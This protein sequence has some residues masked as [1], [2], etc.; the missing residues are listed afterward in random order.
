MWGASEA[1]GG[2][3]LFSFMDMTWLRKK[4]YLKS[5]GAELLKDCIRLSFVLYHPSWSASTW[6]ACLKHMLDQNMPTCKNLLVEPCDAGYK[7]YLQ[8]GLRWSQR[9]RIEPL[10]ADCA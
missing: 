9:E 6:D 2:I 10:T 1:C 7:G 8:K 5:K 4:G 3:Q